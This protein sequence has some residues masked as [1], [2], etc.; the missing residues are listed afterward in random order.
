[1]P[2]WAVPVLPWE[3]T[4]N[5]TAKLIVG[6]L[7]D[8]VL[9]TGGVIVALKGAPDTWGW[10]VALVVGVM[11]SAKHVRGMMLDPGR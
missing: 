10:V 6:A 2:R 3:D 8:F 5:Q 4:M 11:A 1:M 9:T 7:T